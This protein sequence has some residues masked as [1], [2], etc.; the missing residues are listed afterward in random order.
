LLKKKQEL[1]HKKQY[2]NTVKANNFLSKTSKNAKIIQRKNETNN[3]IPLISLFCNKKSLFSASEKSFLNYSLFIIHSKIE[4]TLDRLP[5]KHPIKGHFCSLLI[6][7]IF[8]YPLFLLIRYSVFFRL[9]VR[10]SVK[11]LTG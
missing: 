3:K 8:C 5:S 9:S 7:N 4:M 1:L 10:F 11:I 6:S 2:E